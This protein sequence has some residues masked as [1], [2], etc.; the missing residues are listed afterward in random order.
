M[1]MIVMSFLQVNKHQT[2]LFTYDMN[3]K[4]FTETKLM[5]LWNRYVCLDVLS[6]AF[7]LYF[8]SFSYIA[9]LCAK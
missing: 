8:V 4:F 1:G 3:Q 5:V 7:K 9:L 6:Q 2:S